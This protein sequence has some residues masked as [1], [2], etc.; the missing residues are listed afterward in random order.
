METLFFFF[1]IP[2]NLSKTE[3]TILLLLPNKVNVSMSKKKPTRN[4]QYGDY[5]TPILPLK[6]RIHYFKP[7]L[8]YSI[9]LH[10][11]VSDRKPPH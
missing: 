6:S 7:R 8:G 5:A 2:L 9:T 1:K 11:S 3:D 4:K 10:S